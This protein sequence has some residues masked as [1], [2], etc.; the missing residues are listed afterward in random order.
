MDTAGDFR[1]ATSYVWS[2]YKLTLY[3][4]GSPRNKVSPPVNLSRAF[5]I[6]PKIEIEFGVKKS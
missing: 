6:E 4:F 3:L 1:P 5:W 2:Y